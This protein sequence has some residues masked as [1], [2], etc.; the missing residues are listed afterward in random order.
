[1]NSLTGAGGL[2]RVSSPEPTQSPDASRDPRNIKQKSPEKSPLP[3]RRFPRSP[4]Q[5]RRSLDF[6]HRSPDPKRKSLENKHLS[7]NRSPQP[8]R[9]SMEVLLHVSSYESKQRSPENKQK[10]PERMLDLKQTQRSQKD[11]KE[12]QPS[13]VVVSSPNASEGH[14][15]PTPVKMEH[16]PSRSETDEESDV[17]HS[18]SASEESGTLL[19]IVEQP[20][21]STSEPTQH[22]MPLVSPTL[23]VAATVEDEPSNEEGTQEPH[24]NNAVISEDS[25]DEALFD[26]LEGNAKTADSTTDQ[27]KHVTPVSQSE[28]NV[29]ET[30]PKKIMVT[31][32]TEE[33]LEALAK[34]DEVLDLAAKEGI[35]EDTLME[36]E[37]SK[38]GEAQEEKPD[39][40]VQGSP[41]DS[42]L[43]GSC[44]STK[45]S[46]EVKL[47]PAPQG[48]SDTVEEPREKERESGPVGVQMTERDERT[49]QEVAFRDVQ[50]DTE[51]PQESGLVEDVTIPEFGDKLTPGPDAKIVQD[52]EP[53]EMQPEDPE[54]KTAEDSKSMQTE[55]LLSQDAYE[56]KELKLSQDAEPPEDK[57]D[58]E[59]A[60]LSSNSDMKASQESSPKLSQDLDITLSQDS[61][62]AD[63]KSLQDSLSVD[64]TLSQNS[65]TAPI[66]KDTSHEST[67]GELDTSHESDQTDLSQEH[68]R[69]EPIEETDKPPD[70]KEDK[71]SPESRT[72]EEGKDTEM[73][74]R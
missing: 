6:K 35:E 21:T 5:I 70:L 31:R 26:M 58:S 56:Q 3:V 15:T 20:E 33:S 27:E 2:I 14:E 54:S 52:S 17:M 10:T 42:E 48:G 47:S 19:D 36:E 32:S 44:E 30:E 64:V 34:L 43:E 68:S 18:K 24:E 40:E 13:P 7:P 57:M 39:E 41:R 60:E 51:T 46:A 67:G 38:S 62:Q 29:A 66:T 65:T 59:T 28:L 61:E 73:S 71:D 55:T 8:K 49:S 74:Y 11:I 1:M 69:T 25:L 4:E 72:E 53:I 16:S 50:P 45:G 12:K 9:K 22:G 37:E 23:K 63:I